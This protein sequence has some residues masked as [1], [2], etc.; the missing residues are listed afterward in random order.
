M[1]GDFTDNLEWGG[2]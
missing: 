1:S 2:R